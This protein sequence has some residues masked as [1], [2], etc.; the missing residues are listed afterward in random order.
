M[1]WR[2]ALLAVSGWV[3]LVGTGC[4]ENHRKGGAFDRAMSKDIREQQVQREGMVL[5]EDEDD[6]PECPPGKEAHLTCE[7][8]TCAWVCK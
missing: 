2:G 7:A 5:D 1:G 6:L 3:L 4:P 8:E